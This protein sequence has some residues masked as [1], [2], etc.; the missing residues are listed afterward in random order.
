MTTDEPSV[1]QE[2]RS[3]RDLL[4]EMKVKLDSIPDHE[5][6]LRKLEERKFPLP[7]IATILAFAS[8]VANVVMY[9]LAK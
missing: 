7:T 3:Q 5:L 8:I 6:R 4:I 9:A 1:W 2:L